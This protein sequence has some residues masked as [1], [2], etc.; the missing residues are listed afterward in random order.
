MF[1]S[2]RRLRTLAGWAWLAIAAI[3]F[4]PTVSRLALAAPGS[5]AAGDGATAA[6]HAAMSMA[7]D[8][9]MAGDASMVGEAG[10]AMHAHS[11]ARPGAPALGDPPLPRHSHT[12]DH[13]ALCA[14]AAAAF[15]FTPSAPSLAPTSD[16]GLAPAPIDAAPV[17]HGLEWRPA[18]SRGPPAA[19]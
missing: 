1:A 17:P 15:V 12:L 11:G 6:M 18:S 7:G 4:A 14:V 19:A 16:D 13:C 10:A 2:R 3:A 9:S 8:T 5:F